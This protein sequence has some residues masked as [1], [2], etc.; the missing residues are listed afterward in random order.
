MDWTLVALACLSAFVGAYAGARLIRKITLQWVQ[1]LVSAMLLVI[2]L[3][4]VTG[5][6]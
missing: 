5:Q 4:L 1:W 3:G 6:L 2:G